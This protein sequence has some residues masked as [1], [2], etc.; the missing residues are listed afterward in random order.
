M[1]KVGVSGVEQ[2][3]AT[4]CDDALDGAEVRPDMFSEG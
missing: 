4:D 3:D 2:S 1:E